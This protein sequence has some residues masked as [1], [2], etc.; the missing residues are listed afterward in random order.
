[1]YIR[2]RVCVSIL[3]YGG[4]PGYPGPCNYLRR[5]PLFCA[6]A[7]LPPSPIYT[8]GASVSPRFKG[9]SCNNNLIERPLAARVPKLHAIFS[10][11]VS[12]RKAR[13]LIFHESTSTISNITH[14]RARS[15]R[16]ARRWSCYKIMLNDVKLARSLRLRHACLV[17]FFGIIYY[18]DGS[19]HRA[20]ENNNITN[21]VIY[22]YIYILAHHRIYVRRGYNRARERRRHRGETGYNTNV[23]TYYVHNNRF[24]SAVFY[25]TFAFVFPRHTGVIVVVV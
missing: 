7:F 8:R 19:A 3:H 22:I 24:R 12:L 18:I 6:A 20:Y 17:M 4:T 16:K 1:M 15:I 9:A 5:F 25:Y 13:K 14:I 21:V 23:M 11:Y 10:F 2:V